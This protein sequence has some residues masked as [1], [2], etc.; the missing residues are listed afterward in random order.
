MD[1]R[2]ASTAFYAFGSHAAIGF[3]PFAVDD[4]PADHPMGETYG[5]LKEML[6]MLAEYQ[7]NGRTG[8]FYQED[9]KT[10]I[11]SVPGDNVRWSRRDSMFIESAKRLKDRNIRIMLKPHLWLGDG[12]R[13][14]VNLNSEAEW[15]RYGCP[16]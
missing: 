12:W 5:L 2:A 16:K 10:S 9:E 8:G 11:M 1:A 13:S 7:A 6:P 14:N 15:K 4:L 3:G